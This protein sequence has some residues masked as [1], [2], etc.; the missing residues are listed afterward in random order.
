MQSKRVLGGGDKSEQTGARSPIDYRVAGT[1]TY[2]IVNQQR[3]NMRLPDEVQK[4][5]VFL[6]LRRVDPRT[7]LERVIYGGTAFLIAVPAS[8]EGANFICLVTARHVAEKLE[9]GEFYIRA[10]DR[11]GEGREIVVDGGVNLK[12]YYHP[13]DKSVDAAVAMWVPPPDIDYLY[14]PHHMFLDAERMLNKG[15]GVGDEVYVTGLFRLMHG[16]KRN[17][18]IVRTGNIAMLPNERVPVS[19][20]HAPD[21]EAYLIEARSIGGLSGSPVFAQRSIKVQAVEPSGRTP[22]AAGAVFLI[23]LIH[24]H[25]NLPEHEVDYEAD[26]NLWVDGRK[27]MWA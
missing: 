21:I 6:G 13:T 10:N 27:L 12:W 11:N 9:H 22:V 2:R 18:P 17:F 4:C 19:N 14:V 26:E 16:T 23:G 20:W 25:W 8:F 7:G 5:V 24:G 15:I 1:P 3:T